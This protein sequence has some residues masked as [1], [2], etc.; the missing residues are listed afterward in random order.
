MAFAVRRRFIWR[1]LGRS[2]TLGERTVLL[3]ILNVTPDSFSDG[4]QYVEVEHA[5]SR[6]CEM[7]DL[8]ADILDIGG[9]STRP[10]SSPVASTDELAR[11]VPVLRGIMRVRP[12]AILSVDTYRAETARAALDAGAAII[13]DVSGGLWDPAMLP[14][15]AQAGCGLVLM[16]T[17]GSPVEWRT[18][19]PLLHGEAVPLVMRELRERCAAATHAGVA[20]ENIVLDPGFG[21][22]KSFDENY[23]LLAELSQLHE[24]GQP[25]LAGVSRKGF[26]RRVIEGCETHGVS[27]EALR[28]ATT[29]ANVAAV[30]SGAHILRVHDVASARHAAAIADRIL[31]ASQEGGGE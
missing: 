25:L 29:A 12:H 6:A 9:E 27:A 1:T 20:S 4:G 30:L 14:F 15:C 23:P 21:F 19:P 2:I 13:N 3:G 22:G 26:L 16:H 5:I 18:L 7:L 10:G 8:G 11:V 28:D 17:R 31:Q 24:L